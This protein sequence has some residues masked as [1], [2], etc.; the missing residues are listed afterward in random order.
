MKKSGQYLVYDDGVFILY[1]GHPRNPYSTRIDVTMAVKIGMR[2]A[3]GRI[4]DIEYCKI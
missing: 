1:K 3:E 4:D 2:I